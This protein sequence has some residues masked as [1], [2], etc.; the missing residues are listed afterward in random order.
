MNANLHVSFSGLKAQTRVYY[1]L[2]SIHETFDL[3]VIS[4]NQKN[5]VMKYT[6]RSKMNY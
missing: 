4:N 1:K 5:Q 3:L 6:G 2:K